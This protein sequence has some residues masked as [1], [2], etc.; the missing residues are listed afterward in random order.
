MTGSLAVLFELLLEH[1]AFLAYLA[2]ELALSRFEEILCLS[3]ALRLLLL[4]YELIVFLRLNLFEICRV[5][6]I[7]LLLWT[8]I[9]FKLL[10]SIPLVLFPDPFLLRI[11][12][13]VNHFKRGV[14]ALFCAFYG[15][16]RLILTT[17]PGSRTHM[18]TLFLRRAQFTCWL[19][20]FLLLFQVHQPCFERLAFSLGI[21]QLFLKVGSLLDNNSLQVAFTLGKAF[22]F[23][24]MV[25]LKAADLGPG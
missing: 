9:L 4:G 22:E 3:V 24:F 2:E 16:L 7:M 1:K 13:W 25:E 23:K 10:F 12:L 20:P 18:D 21:S 19:G 15:T 14:F 5:F 6:E 8:R 11:V 17:I